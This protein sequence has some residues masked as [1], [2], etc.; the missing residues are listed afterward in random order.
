[1]CCFVSWVCLRSTAPPR[2][3]PLKDEWNLDGRGFSRWVS[4]RLHQ[5]SGYCALWPMGLSLQGV[6]RVCAE[7]DGVLAGLP[8]VE[9][10]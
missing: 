3:C 8:G 7:A 9:K 4:I 10:G 6:S 2:P 5:H 1:M